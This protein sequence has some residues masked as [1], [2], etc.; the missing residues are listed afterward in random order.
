MKLKIYTE[1]INL[2]MNMSLHMIV[3][4]F[5][6]VGVGSTGIGTAGTIASLDD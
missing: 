6:V 2:L 3:E 4:T 5:N 1:T